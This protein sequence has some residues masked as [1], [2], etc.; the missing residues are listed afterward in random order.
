M[1]DILLP[2]GETYNSQ[3]ERI[4]EAIHGVMLAV[5]GM[6]AIEA[7]YVLNNAINVVVSYTM[8]AMREQDG[9]GNE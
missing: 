5:E 9:V 3:E 7:I 1:T 4:S 6:D 2:N 8:K